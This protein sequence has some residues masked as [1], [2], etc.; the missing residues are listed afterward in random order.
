MK[1]EVVTPTGRALDVEVDSVTAPGARGEFGVLPGHRPAL[2]MLGGGAISYAG[3]TPGELFISGGVAELRADAVLVL[4]DEVTK[5]DAV[6]RVRAESL[7]QAAVEALAKIEVL[8]DDQVLRL[9]ADRAYA[10][11]MLKV[12]GH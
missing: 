10:E 11:A 1:L 9:S 7:L 12:A 8:E 5:P 4:A 6:D 3:V 2:M